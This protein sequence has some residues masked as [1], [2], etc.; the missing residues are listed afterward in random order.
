MK[1]FLSFLSAIAVAGCFSSCN[2]AL[3]DDYVPS[4]GTPITLSAQLQQ[5][6]VTRANE[7]GFVTGDRMGIYIVDYAGTAPG[8]LDVAANRA[9]NVLYTFDG[10]NYK[11]T[12]P[13]QLYWKDSST[14]VDVYG[15]YPGINYIDEPKA[16][17]FEVSELQNVVPE[18]GGM[19]NYEASDFLWGK[20]AKVSPTEQAITVKYSHRM[21]GIWVY[22]KAGE[23]I[24]ATE[25]EK[26]DKV[27][28]IENTVRTATINLTDGVPVPSGEVDKGIAM[29]P[30]SGDSYRAVIVPQKVAA[31]KKL[32]S[33]T[34]DGI[35]YTHSLAS[36]MNYVMGKIHNFTININKVEA[37]GDYELKVS[38]D[39]ITDWVNDE[40]SHAFSSTAYV[41]IH[42]PKMGTLKQCITE[43]GYDYTT[44]QNLKVTGE[45]TTKDFEFLNKEMLGLKHLNLQEVK[46]KQAK[47]GFDY[48]R[49]KDVV[50]DEAL[51]ES[52][53]YGNKN[54]RSIILP[55][56]LKCIGGGAFSESQLMYSTLEIPEGVTCIGGNAFAHNG[57]NGVELVLPST[58]DTICGGAFYNCEY[59][60]EF[61]LT[62]NIKHLGEYMIYDG[63]GNGAPNFYGTFHLPSGLKELSYAVFCGLGSNGSITGKIE[64]PQGITEIADAAF[65]ID[66]GNRIDLTFPAG[67]RRIGKDAFGGGQWGRH[68]IRFNSIHFN[69]GM[70]VIDDCAFYGC[71]MPF[72][73]VLPENLTFIGGS[74]FFN[75]G[76]EGELVIPENCLSMKGGAFCRNQ[77]SKLT[78]PSRLEVIED[79]AFECVGPITELTIPKYVDYIGDYAFSGNTYLQTVICLNPEPPTLGRSPF[80]P[81]DWESDGI[82][83]D[84]V[85]LQVPEQSVELYRNADGWREF[86][87]ITAYRELAFNVPEIVTLDKGTTRTGILRSEGAWEVAESPSWVTVSPSSSNNKKT[88]VTVTL[89][90]Q[91]KGGATREG[92]IV[93]RLKDKDYTTYTTIRQVAADVAED[94]TIVLQEA[95]AGAPYSVPL[96]L[97]GDGYNADDIASGKYLQEMHEQ[98]EHLFSVEPYKSY[99][100]Y[101]TVSTAIACSPES[102]T[103]EP[104]KFKSEDYWESEADMVWK[105]AL[106][107]GKDITEAREAYTT[108]LVLYNTEVSIHST[109]ISDNGRT[110]SWMG[111]STDSYPFDQRGYILH[112]LGGTAFAKLGPEG[113]SHFNFMK[114]CTCPGCNMTN[115]YNSMRS[116]GWYQNVST[117]GQMNDVP[118]SHYIFHEK[119]APYVD[120]YE[121]ALNH[122]R[123][124]YRSENMSVM[125]NTYI[126]YYNTISREIIV[127]RIMECAGLPFSMEDFLAKDKIE[128][129][130]EL[131]NNYEL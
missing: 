101:F 57:Y 120:I 85:V 95:S 124:T 67:V 121:G 98:M 111:K 49:W 9:S 73:I 36:E 39:G 105:Y 70:E 31:N 19:S 41:V 90:A 6:N 112:E 26:L 38:Y 84:K 97:V 61:I 51:P 16:Y 86:Q 87:N 2:D 15:Y 108:V 60:C 43:A 66:F 130:E 106:A 83:Y 58:L 54:I 79:G 69:N 103:N 40:T 23:G 7:Q 125:G 4:Q 71:N 88:E 126:P 34:L 46:I 129:P 59:K 45:L 72:P 81:H 52:A 107:H 113:V 10:D 20:T 75:C 109:D 91:D 29:L 44:M 131:V 11:W 13:T 53:F 21:A 80:G 32:I 122:S 89:D 25:W 48:D 68:K 128:L 74:A 92:R 65:S 33:V 96:F 77:I 93:F 63:N 3:V 27:V 37:S 127:R 35:T 94:E 50:R 82:Y 117:S 62:D 100:D 28:Q 5:Q 24:T 110:V 42:C 22:L 99:R 102:G 18:D 116:K 114:D 76:I 56:S 14:P 1:K 104:M 12:A 17:Q 64:I 119:Y 8:I 47:M 118:W 55:I 123:S 30:Q 115:T 78:L